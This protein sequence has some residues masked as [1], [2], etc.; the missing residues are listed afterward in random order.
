MPK[1]SPFL[2]FPRS[3]IAGFHLHIREKSALD[4]KC[5]QAVML[6]RDNFDRGQHRFPPPPPPFAEPPS[7]L[8]V[9]HLCRCLS[10]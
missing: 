6:L 3:E 1:K 8:L 7:A 10:M 5:H 9:A 4:F 2:P